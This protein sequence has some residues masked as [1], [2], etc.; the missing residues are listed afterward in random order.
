MLSGLTAEQKDTN[1]HSEMFLANCKHEAMLKLTSL[2]SNDIHTSHL[3]QANKRDK[4]LQH[5]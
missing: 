2:F 4:S 3:R 5:T 1:G